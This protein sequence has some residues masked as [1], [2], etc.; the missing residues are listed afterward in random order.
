MIQEALKVAYEAHDGQKRKGTGFPYIIHP[1]RVADEI[2]KATNNLDDIIIAAA[3]CHDVIEDCPIKKI[4]YF[5]NKLFELDGVHEIVEE[6]TRGTNEDK[7]EYL[8]SFSTK[9]IK[10]LIIKIFDRYDNIKDFQKWNNDYAGEYADKAKIIYDIYVHR[11][12]E[13]SNLYGQEIIKTMDAMLADIGS[14]IYD[15]KMTIS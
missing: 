12:D 14:I 4:L 9:S 8:A 7:K 2:M 15:W 5:S 3:L 11:K 13:I 10:S 1:I 6:L